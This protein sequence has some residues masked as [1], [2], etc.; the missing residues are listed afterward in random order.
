[1]GR[2][3]Q[4]VVLIVLVD[5]RVM[6]RAVLDQPRRSSSVGRVAAV[7]SVPA[8]AVQDVGAIP[9]AEVRAPRHCVWTMY[10][11]Q[12]RCKHS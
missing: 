6:V 10:E 1:M 2:S 9:S 7:V 11:S 8:I 5:R 3:C 12:V 4:V